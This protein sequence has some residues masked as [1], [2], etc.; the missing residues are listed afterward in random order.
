[1]NAAANFDGDE[2]LEIGDQLVVESLAT[3][4]GEVRTPDGKPFVPGLPIPV[5][6]FSQSGWSYFPTI[7]TAGRYSIRVPMG[8]YR[9][10]LDDRQ[11]PQRILLAA[12]EERVMNLEWNLGEVAPPAKTPL[13]GVVRAPDGT[14]VAK[15]R[16]LHH[17]RPRL[18]LAADDAGQFHFDRGSGPAV[19]YVG[20]PKGDLAGYKEMDATQQQVDIQLS[21]TATVV[22]RVK[23]RNGQPISGVQVN[24]LLSFPSKTWKGGGTN[25]FDLGGSTDKQGQFRITGVPVGTSIFI[26]VQ[27]KIGPNRPGESRAGVPIDKAGDV[28]IPDTIVKEEPGG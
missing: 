1:M 25:T 12:G 3:L 17:G 23:D 9:L 19:L 21:P 2:N 26:N 5:S 4:R 24:L 10:G 15:A 6:L 14:P 22:G 11:P 13:R 7:D 28:E 27:M 18:D 16:I 20:S 8:E